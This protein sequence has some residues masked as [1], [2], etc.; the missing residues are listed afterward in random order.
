MIAV[1]CFISLGYFSS[2]F[3]EMNNPSHPGI[4]LATESNCNPLKSRCWAGQDKIRLGFFLPSQAQYLKPF[5]VELN[6]VGIENT[7]IKKVSVTFEMS[8]MDM[9][10][11]Q[12]FLK[13]NEQSQVYIGEAILPICVTGRKDWSA[14]VMVETEDNRYQ[15]GFNFSVIK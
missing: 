7:K 6:I 14:K 4:N 10:I 1:I 2:S 12:F 8:E 3:M 11:N 5:P 9:G 13:K 15:A